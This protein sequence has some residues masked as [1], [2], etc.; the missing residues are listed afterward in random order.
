MKEHMDWEQVRNTIIKM[1]RASHLSDSYK[2]RD[3][4]WTSGAQPKTFI[5]C[6]KKGHMVA[7]CS[8]PKDKL[9]CKHCDMMI[10]HNTSAFFKK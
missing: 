7:T 5:A 3:W 8:V 6:G 10:S 1:D 2:K 9:Y 4:M